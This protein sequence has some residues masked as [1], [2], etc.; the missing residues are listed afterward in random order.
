MKLATLN[1]DHRTGAAL[2]QVVHCC[3]TQIPRVLGIVRNRRCATKLVAYRFI[4][5]S[6]LDTSSFEA[7]L[8]FALPLASQ[9][10]LGHSKVSL[11]VAIDVLK[12]GDF[13]WVKVL[14]ECLGEEHDS[15]R[16]VHSL[17]LDNCAFNDVC[18][19]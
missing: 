10:D 5:H 7:G 17:S 13:P 4:H 11:R 3:V 18:D 9:V 14:D 12:L 1:C 6:H 15:V 16:P 19:F 8:N 2:Q